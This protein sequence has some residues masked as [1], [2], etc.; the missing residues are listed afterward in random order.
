MADFENA[1]GGMK[2]PGYWVSM[3]E[4]KIFLEST[5]FDETELDPATNWKRAWQSQA[6]ESQVNGYVELESALI[7]ADTS[8]A[9]A[10]GVVLTQA[11]LDQATRFEPVWKDDRY[12]IQS[13]S[14]LL[15]S[16]IS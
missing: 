6:V 14:H 8:L 1:R 13:L 3:G 7:S 2:F 4:G 5:T 9:K 10:A 15:G 12:E 16:K 11:D